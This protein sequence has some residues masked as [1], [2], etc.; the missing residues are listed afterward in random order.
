MFKCVVC[1][2]IFE[3]GEEAVWKDD[4]GIEGGYYE[5]FSG[6]PMCKNEYEETVSCEA[7]GEGEFL[8]EGLT[9]GVCSNCIEE[10]SKDTEFCIKCGDIDRTP[11]NVNGAIAAQLSEEEIN[12]ILIDY[13]K[14]AGI[15]FE[16]F[17]NEDR[18]WFAE[19]IKEEQTTF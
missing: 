1:G 13:V 18:G 10:Y 3:E 16:K 4:H 7:C 19:M 8:E 17:V 14:G 5:T 11:V 2:C 15:S 9:S 6:C 12:E